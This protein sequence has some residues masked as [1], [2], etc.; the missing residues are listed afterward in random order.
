MQ[1]THE[2]HVHLPQ[3]G[4]KGKS[5]YVVCDSVSCYSKSTER[6]ILYVKHVMINDDSLPICISWV[7]SIRGWDN[8]EFLICFIQSLFN[9]FIMSLYKIFSSRIFHT[10]SKKHT[11]THTHIHTCY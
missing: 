8:T 4:G 1:A 10:V 3:P 9:I 11:H 7:E 5:D 2:L 6:G